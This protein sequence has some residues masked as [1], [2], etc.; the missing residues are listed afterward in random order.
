MNFHDNQEEGTFKLNEN[1]EKIHLEYLDNLKKIIF[2]P[3][4]EDIKL[5]C[6]KNLNFNLKR[7]KSK[8]VILKLF[9]ISLRIIGG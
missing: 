5:S 4:V 1:V 2:S 3:N 8:L 6:L 9:I 7:K